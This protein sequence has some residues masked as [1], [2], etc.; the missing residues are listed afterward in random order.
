MQTNLKM[1]V[2]SKFK[3]NL[4]RPPDQ[5]KSLSRRLPERTGEELPSQSPCHLGCVFY[6]ASTVCSF[7]DIPCSLLYK[8][9]R[10]SPFLYIEPPLPLFLPHLP[11]KLV[12]SLG[13][14]FSGKCLLSPAPSLCSAPCTDPG[15]HYC[16]HQVCCG[17]LCT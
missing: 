8:G 12:I 7:L 11:G 2:T 15:P 10:L 9:L 3:T 6:E 13:I 5:L 14:A 17:C 4:A 16:S 1:F